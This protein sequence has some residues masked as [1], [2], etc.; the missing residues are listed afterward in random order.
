MSKKA[1]RTAAAASTASSSTIHSLDALRAMQQP[2][3]VQLYVRTE[4]QV[5]MGFLTQGKI[6]S[7]LGAEGGDLLK[8]SGI[9]P[10]SLSN[11]RKAQWV[12]ETFAALKPAVLFGR[13]DGTTAEFDEA[14]YDTLTLRECD[15]LQ[16]AFTQVGIV[17]HRP[18]VAKSRELVKSPTW[19]D[20][21]ECWFEHGATPAGLEERRQQQEAEA[22]AERARIAAMEEQIR[23]LQQQAAAT[24]A[25]DAPPPA[26]AITFNAPVETPAATA[27]SEPEPETEDSPETNEPEEEAASSNDE[28]ESEALEPPPVQAFE[29]DVPLNEAAEDSNMP[30]TPEEVGQAIAAVGPLPTLEGIFTA[31]EHLQ[32]EITQGIELADLEELRTFHNELSQLLDVVDAHI[33]HKSPAP[34]A[35]TGGKRRAKAAA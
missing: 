31:I 33:A 34:V 7:V 28:E 19:A 11:A 12:L 10:S 1:L 6:L 26:P 13:L 24:P 18:T 30:A 20:D 29:E 27:E 8:A 14:F 16:K 17:Q 4:E 2:E 5:R 22:A 35:A 25:A 32:E 21:L 3:C 15:L 23:Q 9:K